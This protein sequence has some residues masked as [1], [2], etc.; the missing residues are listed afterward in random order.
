VILDLAELPEGV[1]IRQLI[2]FSP[3]DVGGLRP[4]DIILKLDDQ[5]MKATDEVQKY[6][7]SRR[8]GQTI[9]IEFDRKGTRRQVELAL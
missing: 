5:P 2:R 3:A 7:A 9:S 6:V 4:G 8:R 1:R